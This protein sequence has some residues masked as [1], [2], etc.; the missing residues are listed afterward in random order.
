MDNVNRP[1]DSTPLNPTLASGRPVP[2]SGPERR[3]AEFQQSSIAWNVQ[4]PASTPGA[5]PASTTTTLPSWLHLLPQGFSRG[6]E[7]FLERMGQALLDDQ[8]VVNFAF[9]RSSVVF[10][11][12]S[13][14]IAE[15]QATLM[16]MRNV[17][18]VD[19]L[20]AQARLKVA[21][22]E[23]QAARDASELR[24]GAATRM[25]D[26]FAASALVTHG[27]AVHEAERQ[28]HAIEDE[29]AQTQVRLE[30]CQRDVDAMRETISKLLSSS[31]EERKARRE[32]QIEDARRT[33][34]FDRQLEELN[35]ALEAG[36]LAYSPEKLSV[37]AC[38]LVGAVTAMEGRPVSHLIGALS[39]AVDG[40]AA[41]PAIGSLGAGQG[42]LAD[43][44]DMV[45]G[46]LAGVAFGFAV[47]RRLR[48][49]GN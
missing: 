17:A 32:Q 43:G 37:Y 11:E 36:L 1:I 38:T 9:T 6:D 4:F 44:L 2:A 35:G 24:R 41:G 33:L 5:S 10:E 42:P 25:P 13:Q 39:A 28:Y 40:P 34:A 20:G 23:L 29:C 7:P 27:V 16:L 30:K 48:F 49:G 8:G 15:Q 3:A 14:T 21:R 26:P 47:I 22:V 45:F 12:G 31:P 46:M 18:I 19:A